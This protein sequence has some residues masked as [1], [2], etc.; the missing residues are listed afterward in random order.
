L[1]GKIKAPTSVVLIVVAGAEVKGRRVGFPAVAFGETP[2][3]SMLGAPASYFY[4][5][6][7]LFGKRFGNNV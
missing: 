5:R 1:D 3:A 6:F 2:I 7:R 4:S